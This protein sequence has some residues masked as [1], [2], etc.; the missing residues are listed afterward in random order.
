[1]LIHLAAQPIVLDSF[2]DPE[3]TYMVNVIATLKILKFIKIKKL[4]M[5]YLVP[6]IKFIKI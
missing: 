2:K 5:F 4:E 1:M 6:L 3:N